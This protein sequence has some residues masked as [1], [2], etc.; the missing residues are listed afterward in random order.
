QFVKENNRIPLL[1]EFNETTDIP[2]SLYKDIF[3]SWTKAVRA[4]GYE[5]ARYAKSAYSEFTDEQILNEI[6]NF[7]KEHGHVPSSKEMNEFDNFP[8]LTIY[9]ERFGSW[10]KALLKCGYN[11]IYSREPLDGTEHCHICGYTGK[12][13]WRFIAGKRACGACHRHTPNHR[14][15]FGCSPINKYA[16]GYVFHHLHLKLNN[17]DVDRSIGIYIPMALHQSVPHSS[18]SGRGMQEINELALQWYLD[19]HNDYL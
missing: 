12:T 19:D 4:A 7:V 14:N 1:K 5:P 3:G 18:Q 17:G 2:N 13:A 8:G 6:H 15:T 16:P 9:T 11:P 10:N